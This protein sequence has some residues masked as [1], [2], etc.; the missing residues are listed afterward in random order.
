MSAESK[1]KLVRQTY[2]YGCTFNHFW[3]IGK[4]THCTHG[5]GANNSYD[6][7]S[8]LEAELP[9]RRRVDAESS[10]TATEYVLDYNYGC[11]FNDFFG[12][13]GSGKGDYF[14]HARRTGDS[15]TR[16]PANPDAP[17]A[18]P[19]LSRGL[20]V[21]SLGPVIPPSTTTLGLAVPLA[22]PS[23]P[24]PPVPCPA[25]ALLPGLCPAVPLALPSLIPVTPHD[26]LQ[27]LL[28]EF[29][30]SSLYKSSQSLVP[31]TL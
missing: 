6:E 19:S 9:K 2:D 21:T 23:R 3:G 12:G 25:P 10:S 20:A 7:D 22:V 18:S 14:T 30:K 28:T 11:T 8:D 29:R 27:V 1:P 24:A 5:P 15:K 13:K 26:A 4:G 17:S 16:P 31:L